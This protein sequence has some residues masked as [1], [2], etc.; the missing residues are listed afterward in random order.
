MTKLN[1]TAKLIVAGVA[2]A[3]LAGTLVACSKGSAPAAQ[4]TKQAKQAQEKTLTACGPLP[5]AEAGQIMGEK[6][7]EVPQSK[8]DSSVHICQYIDP[9]NQVAVLLKV[10]PFQGTD[11][12]A[13]LKQDAAVA[14]GVSKNSVIPSNIVPAK[15]LSDG[16]FFVETTTSPTDRSVQLH[17]I[18]KKLKIMIQVGNPKTFA[19]GE[20]QALALAQKAIENIQN[21]KASQPPTAN[22]ANME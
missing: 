7:I 5:Q 3:L 6:L 4:Q 16:A 1:R 15:G 18:N 20:K 19:D 2:A 13:T 14:E 11:A 12:A 21:G 22:T 9:N 17:F 8:P 10:S